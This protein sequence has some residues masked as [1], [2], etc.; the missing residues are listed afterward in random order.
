MWRLA[1]GRKAERD[2]RIA[3]ARTIHGGGGA[4]MRAAAMRAMDRALAAM[5]RRSRVTIAMA[6]A[7]LR[8]EELAPLIRLVRAGSSRVVP[9]IGPP[10]PRKASKVMRAQCYTLRE[11][12]AM[13]FTTAEVAALPRMIDVD[14][15]T[16]MHRGA[17]P[18]P[19]PR[20]IG[21]PG[22]SRAMTGVSPRLQPSS[23]RLGCHC[24]TA[25]SVT[26]RRQPRQP[27]CC[28]PGLEK[29]P[30]RPA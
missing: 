30:M 28:R 23:A 21:A 3:A 11:I 19:P 5:R 8:V 16:P 25:A 7:G 10:L 24:S 12:T 6:Q 15:R 20:I 4:A 17:M 2:A 18:N 13:D 9:N 1:A 26:R 22:C 27:E 29:T 14:A